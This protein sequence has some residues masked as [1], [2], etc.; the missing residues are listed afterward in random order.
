MRKLETTARFKKD[1][2]LARRRG[3]DTSKLD[4]VINSL[5]KDKVLPEKNGDHELTGG[6]Y[7][8]HR[9]CHIEPDWLLIYLKRT[10]GLILT[11]VRTGT[12]SD[13]L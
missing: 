8:G 9:E 7:H 4:A 13:L 10:D 6:R 1:A 2:K 3:L 5:L 11:A 12:H